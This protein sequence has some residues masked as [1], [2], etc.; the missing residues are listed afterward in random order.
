VR[1]WGKVARGVTC[2]AAH[3]TSSLGAGWGRVAPK[4]ER[5]ALLSGCGVEEDAV[6]AVVRLDART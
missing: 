3:A 5:P 1:R 4:M 6:V 2:H